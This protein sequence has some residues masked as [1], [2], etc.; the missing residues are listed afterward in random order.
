MPWSPVLNP[1][2]KYRLSTHPLSAAISTEYERQTIKI[3]KIKYG[4]PADSATSLMPLAC[5][6]VKLNLPEMID[7]IEIVERTDQS[8]GA[9]IHFYCAYE[10]SRCG[11][12]EQAITFIHSLGVDQVR[13]CCHKIVNIASV[14]KSNFIISK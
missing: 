1:L 7:D 10:L 11:N 8:L 3:L 9:S 4:W 2:L 13:Q 5:R 14:S 12:L 6:I